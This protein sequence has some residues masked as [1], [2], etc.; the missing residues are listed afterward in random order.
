MENTMKRFMSAALALTFALGGLA[1]AGP[2]EGEKKPV[3]EP[4][5]YTA[6]VKWVVHV[7]EDAPSFDVVKREVKGNKITWILENKRSLGTEITFGYQAT[8]L[9]EDGVKLRTIE[10]EVEPFLMNLS[11]GER[12]RFVLHMPQPEKWKG[13]RKV[14][15]TNGLYN[16]D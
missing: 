3:H 14:V 4:L 9:D 2:R 6:D 13:V 16:G 7:L 12:N 11:K 15:I 8:L 1:Q 5:P 10:I